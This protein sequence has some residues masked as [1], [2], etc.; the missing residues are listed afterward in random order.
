LGYSENTTKELDKRGVRVL[1]NSSE[2]ILDATRDILGFLERGEFNSEF[3]EKLN[4]VR[5]ETSAVGFGD[6]A[7]SFISK[8]PSWVSD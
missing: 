7:P 6:V 4:L 3:M 1:E 5:V 8:N 2:E